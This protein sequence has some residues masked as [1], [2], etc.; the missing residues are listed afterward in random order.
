M[1]LQ[2]GTLRVLVSDEQR[3]PLAGVTVTVSAPPVSQVQVTPA[4]GTCFFP[5]LPPEWYVLRCEL[6]GYST[7]EYPNITIYVGRN[8]SVEATLSPAVEDVITV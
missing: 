8:E 4:D 7:L 2:T 1:P 6:E 5:A 3:S